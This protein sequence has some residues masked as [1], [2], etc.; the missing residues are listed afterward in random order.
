MWVSLG[1]PEN[2]LYFPMG[3]LHGEN[4]DQ[5]ELGSPFF[6]EFHRTDRI[7]SI[8]L[9]KSL[10]SKSNGWVNNIVSYNHFPSCPLLFV[11]NQPI[12]HFFGINGILK[13]VE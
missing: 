7:A 10:L 5:L 6:K 12:K 4:D 3:S 1:A 11:A 2:G 13:R 8:F 9:G